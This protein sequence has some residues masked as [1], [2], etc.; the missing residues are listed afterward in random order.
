MTFSTM[1]ILKNV[2]IVFDE[3]ATSGMDSVIQGA[4]R[5]SQLA[6]LWRSKGIGGVSQNQVSCHSPC[7]VEEA[8]YFDD[9]ELVRKEERNE[10]IYYR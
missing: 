1:V 10:K 3:Y 4:Q 2:H 9:M 7:C 6:Y 8:G 5:K